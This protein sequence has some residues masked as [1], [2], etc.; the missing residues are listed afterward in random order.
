MLLPP[1]TKKTVPKITFIPSIGSPPTPPCTRPIDYLTIKRPLTIR[2]RTDL[3]NYQ[4]NLVQHLSNQKEYL[5]KVQMVYNSETYRPT[6][7]LSLI[8]IKENKDPL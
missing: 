7:S 5:Q 3:Y 4:S 6:H 1:I 8:K 2:G